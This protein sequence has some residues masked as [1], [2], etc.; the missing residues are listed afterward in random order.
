MSND[1]PVSRGGIKKRNPLIGQFLCLALAALSAG[2]GIYGVWAN[3]ARVLFYFSKY[4]HRTLH[5]HGA[6]TWVLAAA[7]LMI[8]VG[9]LLLLVRQSKKTKAEAMPYDRPIYVLMTIGW[10]TEFCMAIGR[11]SGMI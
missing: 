2:F 7:N 9:F 8:T 1:D 11:Y 10:G 5:F 3:D 6:A 4:Q